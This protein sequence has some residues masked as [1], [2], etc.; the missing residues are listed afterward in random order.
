MKK[1]IPILAA[2]VVITIA[3]LKWG[4]K[5]APAP[6]ASV[7]SAPVPPSPNIVKPPATP[8][9]PTPTSA[10]SMQDPLSEASQAWVDKVRVKLLAG[11]AAGAAALVSEAKLSLSRPGEFARFLSALAKDLAVAHP[12]EAAALIFAMRGNDQVMLANMVTEEMFPQGA[13]KTAQWAAQ[14]DTHDMG[15]P[16]HQK[17]GRLWA[18]ENA[19]DATAWIGSLQNRLL[20][21]SAVEGVAWK[22]AQT[23]PQAV[24][25]WAAGMTDPNASQRALLAAAKVIAATDPQGALK[26]SMEIPPGMGRN[27]AVE[28]SAGRWARQDASSAGN[29]VAGLTDIDLQSLAGRAVLGTWQKSD[30]QG[31]AAWV[32]TLPPVVQDWMQ[33]NAA[34]PQESGPQ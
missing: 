22:L 25:E 26:W 29:W 20:I 21:G 14:F 6:V 24:R 19:S 8:A 10:V 15:R 18:G 7:P 34:R 9:A 11:D 23:D 13:A 33:K 31:A 4:Q 28:Y 12:Q 3:W 1:T 27:Q 5:E 30:P 32:T 2:G 16:I 17:L